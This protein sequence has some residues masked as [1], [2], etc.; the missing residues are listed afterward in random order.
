MCFCCGQYFKDE[1]SDSQLATMGNFGEHEL[2]GVY[3]FTK[4][5]LFD[6]LW[7]GE[8][9]S[10]QAEAEAS[11]GSNAQFTNPSGA[12]AVSNGRRR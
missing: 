6:K 7:Q 1:F 3:D 4:R 11:S 10:S 12:E 9:K 8:D 2:T 5:L